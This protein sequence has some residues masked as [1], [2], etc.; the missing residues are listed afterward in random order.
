[1]LKRYSFENVSGW[2]GNAI[3]NGFVAGYSNPVVLQETNKGS[4]WRSEIFVR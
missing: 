4:V 3:P 1:M 2:N